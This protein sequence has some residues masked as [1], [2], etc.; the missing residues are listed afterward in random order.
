MSSQSGLITYFVEETRQIPD[1]VI[2]PFNTS[3]KRLS[4]QITES[5]PHTL[6]MRDHTASI[7]TTL[8]IGI[9]LM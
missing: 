9:N 7:I 2:N 8:V 6:P 1:G 5:A 3:A 4:G